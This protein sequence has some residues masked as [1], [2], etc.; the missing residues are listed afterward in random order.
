[1]IVASSPWVSVGVSYV[2]V[3]GSIAV[4]AWRSRARGRRLAPQVP[5]DQR[6]WMTTGAEPA[7]AER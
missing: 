1:M 6:S 3:F 7:P 5:E 4:L 2:L